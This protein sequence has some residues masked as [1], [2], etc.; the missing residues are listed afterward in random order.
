MAKAFLNSSTKVRKL[1][2]FGPTFKDFC[3]CTKLCYKT[4]QRALITKM[5]IDFQSCSPKHPN[6][7]FLV[8]NLRILIFCMKL[9]NQTNWRALITNMTI[10]FE[11]SSPKTQQS[12]FGPKFIFFW[13][14]MKLYSFTKSRVVIKNLIIVFIKLYLKNT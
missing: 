1:S 9:C 4:N 10:T 6:K 13:F 12:I 2:I 5:T 8:P 7:A 14:W 11:N 3:F